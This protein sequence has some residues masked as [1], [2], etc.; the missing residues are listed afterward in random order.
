MDLFIFSVPVRQNEGQSKG[1]TQP[2]QS[3]EH[4]QWPVDGS[5]TRLPIGQRLLPEAI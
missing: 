4:R 1:P 2:L 3:V 5:K